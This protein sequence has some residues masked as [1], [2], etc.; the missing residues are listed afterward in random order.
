[1]VTENL[2]PNKISVD[3]WLPLFMQ[4]MA[5]GKQ[6]K[7]APIGK[8]MYPFLISKRDNVLLKLPEVPVKR[9]DICLYRR[10]NGIHVLHRVH[11][12]DNLGIYM[13]GDSQTMIEGPLDEE[14]MLAVA[15]KIIRKGKEIPCDNKRY[16]LMYRIWLRLRFCRPVFIWAWFMYRKV[17]RKQ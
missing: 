15:V 3:E 1:M 17:F 9:G 13:L 2:R 5:L 14:Q 8:S 7:L 16:R 10:V 11:H 12:R 6:L 4:Q